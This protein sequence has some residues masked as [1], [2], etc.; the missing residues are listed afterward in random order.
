[1]LTRDV[2][3]AIADPTRRQLLD[4]LAQVDELP[5]YEMTAKF[6]MGR[7]G[8]A[9]HLAILK[10]AGLVADR[11][12]GRESRYHLNADRL[13]EVQEWVSFYQ[14][15]WTQRMDR[16]QDLLES[17]DGADNRPDHAK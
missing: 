13:R 12:V 10:E 8:V 16:L 9:K 7:T 15:F 3:S 2:F 6:G 11:K 17:N 4:A 1:V 14:R 5:L